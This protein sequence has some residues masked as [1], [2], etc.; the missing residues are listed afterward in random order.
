MAPTSTD[1]PNPGPGEPKAAKL[2]LVSAGCVVIFGL[3]ALAAFGIW[4]FMGL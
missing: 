2:I 1:D 3:I 4:Q